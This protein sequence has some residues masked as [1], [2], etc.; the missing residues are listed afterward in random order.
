MDKERVRGGER[1]R[2]REMERERERED[3][4]YVHMVPINIPSAPVRYST[5]IF[6]NFFPKIIR[7]DLNFSSYKNNRYIF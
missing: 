5:R 6:H 1:E 3:D 7:I 4:L 2:E